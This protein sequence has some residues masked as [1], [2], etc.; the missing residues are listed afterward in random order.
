MN[1]CI[2]LRQLRIRI[3]KVIGLKGCRDAVNR[4]PAKK[5]NRAAIVKQPLQDK[6][7]NCSA[8]P[9]QKY[10]HQDACFAAH[11]RGPGRPAISSGMSTPVAKACQRSIRGRN[12]A[13]FSCPS[14]QGFSYW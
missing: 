8:R 12:L 6:P 5:R 7:A 4:T 14:C 3:S 11:S 13:V 1:E 9:R 2:G 10:M